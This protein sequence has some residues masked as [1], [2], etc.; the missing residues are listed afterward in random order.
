MLIGLTGPNAA[1]KGAAAGYLK[2]RG[3]TYLSLSNILR[4]ELRARG[5]EPDR[6][7]LIAIGNELR[8]REGP[9]ILAA[10]ILERINS[11]KSHIIDSIR[12]P[13]EV[14]TLRQ[15]ADFFLTLIDATAEARFER[16]KRRKREKDPTTLETFVDLEKRELAGQ[17]D[18][19][20]QLA[21]TTVLADYV[22]NNDGTLGDLRKKMDRIVSEIERRCKG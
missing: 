12:H 7:A 2:K 10:R 8:E 18:V 6:E 4:E 17:E 16:I 20:Q 3:F 1:G 5:L 19:H 9:G 13:A 14:E 11:E 22:I 21:R 15:R